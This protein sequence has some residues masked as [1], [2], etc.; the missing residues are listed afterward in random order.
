MTSILTKSSPF[1]DLT[2]DT[3][4]LKP[5]K[6]GFTSLGSTLLVVSIGEAFDARKASRYG[7]LQERGQGITGIARDKEGRLSVLEG[8]LEATR[9][10]LNEHALGSRAL[11]GHFNLGIRGSQILGSYR[12]GTQTRLQSAG[13]VLVGVIP[14]QLHMVS[15]EASEFYEQ[16]RIYEDIEEEAAITYR[17]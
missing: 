13:G 3:E 5:G 17:V 1:A 10:L 12:L 6:R 11:L 7:I 4:L 2:A 14:D 9:L 15:P 8:K 16:L